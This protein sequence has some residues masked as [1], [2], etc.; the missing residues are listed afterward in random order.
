VNDDPVH[1][2]ADQYFQWLAVDPKDGSVNIL[3]YDRRRDPTNR[4]QTV[5]LARSTDGGQKFTNYVWSDRPFNAE[6]VFM[7]DYTGLAAF[8]GRVYGIWTEKP[9]ADPEAAALPG[10]K[11]RGTPE[12]WTVHGTT[13]QVGI[14]DFHASH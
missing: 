14:A 12:Y 8:D 10:S 13:V 2:G 3:F 6:N 11:Q 7:G 5:T 1:N 4:T 9:A